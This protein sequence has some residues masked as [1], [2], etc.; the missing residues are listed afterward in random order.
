MAAFR[1]TGQLNL[2]YGDKISAHAR[3]H[4]LNRTDP[5]LRTVR[6]DTFLARNQRDRIGTTDRN[7]FVID[8]PRQ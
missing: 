7:Q 2:I 8:L 4:R 1:V 6:H 5:I 3:R